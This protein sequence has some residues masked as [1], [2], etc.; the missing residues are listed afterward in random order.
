MTTCLLAKL[1]KKR[2]LKEKIKE[3]CVKRKFEIKECIG[4]LYVDFPVPKILIKNKIFCGHM[5]EDVVLECSFSTPMA[6]CS[7]VTFQAAMCEL[8]HKS[9]YRRV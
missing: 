1:R 3:N 4:F 6:V 8:E 9:T 2:N 7:E 5:K